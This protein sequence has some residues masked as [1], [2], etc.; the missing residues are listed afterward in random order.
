MKLM[1]I[2]LFR[3]LNVIKVKYVMLNTYGRKRVKGERRNKQKEN[4]R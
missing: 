3:N 2:L 1:I 4:E